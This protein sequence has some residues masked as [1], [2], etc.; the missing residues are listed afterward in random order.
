MQGSS[1]ITKIMWTMESELDLRSR[2]AQIESN[3]LRT[4]KLVMDLQVDIR[5]HVKTIDEKLLR[6]IGLLNSTIGNGASHDG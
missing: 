1:E 4:E 5:R 3:Q 2:L 6:L